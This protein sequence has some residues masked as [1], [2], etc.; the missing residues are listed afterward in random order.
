MLFRIDKNKLESI[1]ELSFDLPVRHSFL[2][3]RSFSEV[4]SEGG[5]KDIQTLTKKI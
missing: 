2:D 5:E 4:D 1:K 3:P